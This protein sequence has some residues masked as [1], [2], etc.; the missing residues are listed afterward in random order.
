MQRLDRN[1]I[2]NRRLSSIYPIIHTSLIVMTVEVFLFERIL[3]VLYYTR[4]RSY[5]TTY[6]VYDISVY[7]YVKK[8]KKTR[9]GVMERILIVIFEYQN[10]LLSLNYHTKSD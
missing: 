6:H 5:S 10:L 7:Y 4:I 9:K 1:A 2:T 3:L 8:A